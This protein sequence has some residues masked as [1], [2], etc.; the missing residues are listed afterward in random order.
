MRA[1]DILHFS[2]FSLS[3]ARIRSG[4]MLLA[5][6]IGVAAV[7]VLTG[8]GDG[9]RLFITGEFA[10]LGTNLVI[11]LPGRSETASG[12]PSTFVGETPRDLTIGD[13]VALQRLTGVRYV[14]PVNVGEVSIS[15]KGRDRRV[16]LL[17]S[18]SSLM[19]IRHLQLG[20][21]T[22]LPAGDPESMHSV[23]VLGAKV[24]RE[25]FGT[26]SALGAIVRI[27]EYRCRVTGILRSKGRSMGMD[28]QEL[29]IVPVAFAQ[30][31][32]NTEGLFRIIVEA[33]DSST[34]A[35]LKQQILQVISKRHHGEKDITII[36]Q[37]SVVATFNRIFHVLTMTVAGIAAI[38]LIV[39]GILIM[40]VMLVSVS[41]RTAEI[42]LF[43]ALGARNS[44]IMLLF[45]TEAAL[46]SLIGGGLG[47]A[48]GM[49]GIW[50]VG[51]FYP[52]LQATP[53]WWAVAAA[54]GTALVTGIV[55]GLLPARRAARLD[56][57]QALSH[58]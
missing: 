39:A 58:H 51:R 20:R 5:M 13:A 2:L 23:C 18:T 38:S 7:I 21:G 46:L 14:A 33:K 27:G 54:L 3:A 25:L 17:G 56:P 9:A 55:F 30:M 37:D 35:H 15:Y 42:G 34:M 19:D 22:F 26:A 29:V 1:G 40:N 50:G 44:Q 11:I 48:I 53:P 8:V 47:L 49:G 43:K 36:T 10:A 32:L 6:S 52:D 12:T 24:S 28:T 41:Q 57:I 16:P 31:L 45:L 4:L